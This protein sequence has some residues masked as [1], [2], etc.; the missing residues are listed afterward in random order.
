VAE[1]ALSSMWGIGRFPDLSG[2]FGAAKGLGFGRFELNHAVTTAM[3]NASGLN[4]HRIV[5]IHEPCPA[6]HSIAELRERGWLISAADDEDRRRAVAVIRRS[7]EFAHQVGASVV[8]VHPGEVDVDPALDRALLGLFKQGAA[9]EL[10]FAQ[11]R[12]R[13]RSARED[14]A[15]IAMRSVRRSLAELAECAAGLGV[16][17]G[18]ENRY[19]YHEIPQPDELEELLATDRGD[20]IG[21]WHDVGHAQVMECLGFSRHED[22]LR[23]FSGRIVGVHLHD[24]VGIQD[25]LAPGLGSLDWDM[26]ARYLPP[27]ALRTCEFQSFNSPEEVAAG[28]SLLVEKGIMEIGQLRKRPQMHEESGR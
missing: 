24:I 28:L 25:H 13:L 16:R 10:Q 3:L 9:G 22:C 7:I 27:D 1:A 14:R 21:Y 4:G 23:R 11:A 19:H 15:G 26:V 20:V 5:S 6:Q 8:I 12:E 17:L 2:F 18:L